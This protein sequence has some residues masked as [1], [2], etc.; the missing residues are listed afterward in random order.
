MYD[1]LPLT[2]IPHPDTVY[3]LR[4]WKNS[5]LLGHTQHARLFV[6]QARDKAKLSGVRWEGHVRPVA[7][8]QRPARQQH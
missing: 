4:T 5:L 1:L 8:D 7:A 2:S 3:N 6:L